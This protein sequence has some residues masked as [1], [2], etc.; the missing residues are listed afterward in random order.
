M[1]RPGASFNQMQMRTVSRSASFLPLALAL[2]FSGGCYRYSYVERASL[3]PGEAVRLRIDAQEA[4]R[5]GEL[6]G[7]D[8]RV[9]D[10]RVV[11]APDSS[12]TLSVR[13][14]VVQQGGATQMGFQRVVIPRSSVVETQ[15]RTLDRGRTITLVALTAVATTAAVITTFNAVRG[16]DEKGTKR[17]GELNR[18]PPGIRIPLRLSIPR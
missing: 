5:L 3:A 2:L 18:L 9:Y 15:R 10:G 17:P 6:L 12:L 11:E 1:R 13:S 14:F 7:R 4:A 16:K 8:D